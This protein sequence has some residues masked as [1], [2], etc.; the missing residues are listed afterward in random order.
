MGTSVDGLAAGVVVPDA[1]LSTAL[2]TLLG[3]ADLR[4][5]LGTRARRRAQDYGWDEAVQLHER[6]YE[7]AIKRWATAA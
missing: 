7:M 1:D 2:V 5:Q 6:A 4:D 3:D